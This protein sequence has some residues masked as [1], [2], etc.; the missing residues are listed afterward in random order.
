MKKL[1][2]NKSTFAPSLNYLT[3]LPDNVVI[4]ASKSGREVGGGAIA[5]LKI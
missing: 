2:A 1:G 5:I 4:Y 3:S